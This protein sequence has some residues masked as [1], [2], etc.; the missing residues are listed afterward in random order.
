MKVTKRITHSS[1]GGTNMHSRVCKEWQ[2]INRGFEIV[3]D[4]TEVRSIQN[5]IVTGLT[6]SLKG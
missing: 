1:N 2:E 3:L 4:L 5:C 6:H